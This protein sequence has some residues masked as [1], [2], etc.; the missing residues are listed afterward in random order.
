MAAKITQTTNTV[1]EFNERECGSK[2]VEITTGTRERM[3]AF[4]KL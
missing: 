3:L 2:K 1:M 4:S